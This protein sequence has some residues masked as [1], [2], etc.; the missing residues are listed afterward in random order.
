[1]GQK[2][3]KSKTQKVIEAFTG[4]FFVIFFIAF[5]VTAIISVYYTLI[6]FAVAVALFFIAFSVGV[7]KNKHAKK[8]LIKHIEQL[9]EIT[10]IVV[11]CSEKA[12]A[13]TNTA[14]VVMFKTTIEYNQRF[15]STTTVYP[16][17][18]GEVIKAY[19]HPTAN[20]S[21]YLSE[22]DYICSGGKNGKNMD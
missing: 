15:Y 21:E 4:I 14:S 12:T 2:S 7:I 1:M 17:V 8:Y 11:N 3:K 9:V 5:F 19:I 13:S 16:S 18:V 10:A 20:T 6:V 22:Y